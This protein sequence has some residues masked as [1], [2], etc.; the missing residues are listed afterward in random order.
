M[1]EDMTK[2]QKAAQ[3]AWRFAKQTIASGKYDMVILDELT[4]LLKLKAI[5]E[6]DL[7]HILSQKPDNLHVVVT[8]RSA[9]QSLLDLADLVS[10]VQ[11]VKHPFQSGIKAQKG[12]EF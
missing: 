6:T 10:D 11:A 7:I 5:D 8:G 9:P 2:D 4:H 12:I 1:I 3:D